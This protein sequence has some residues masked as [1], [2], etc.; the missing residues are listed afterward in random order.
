MNIKTRTHKPS[1]FISFFGVPTSLLLITLAAVILIKD[2]FIPAVAF[3]PLLI[4]LV[5]V[6]LGLSKIDKK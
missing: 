2:L 4:C 5:L 6:R 1:A 3:S